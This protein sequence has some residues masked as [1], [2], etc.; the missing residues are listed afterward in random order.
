MVARYQH[1]LV[2]QQLLQ[3]KQHKKGAMVIHEAQAMV[4]T[5][6]VVEEALVILHAKQH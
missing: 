4:Q 2:H 1:P 3:V 6:T 5:Y